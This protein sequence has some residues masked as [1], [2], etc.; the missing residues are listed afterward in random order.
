MPGY[1]FLRPIGS[2]TTPSSSGRL[3]FKFGIS[4]G[5]FISVYGLGEKKKA[6]EARVSPSIFGKKT[7]CA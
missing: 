3:Y 2:G 1:Q 5:G 7:A 6:Y 4:I